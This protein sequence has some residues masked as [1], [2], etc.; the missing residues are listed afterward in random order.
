V[1]SAIFLTRDGSQHAGKRTARQSAN[2]II[3]QITAAVGFCARR[4]AAG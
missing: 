3:S 1:T 4:R 2:S